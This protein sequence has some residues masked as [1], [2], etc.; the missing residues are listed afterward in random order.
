[1]K[2]SRP[3]L[4]ATVVAL[5]TSLA[6]SG[7]SQVVDLFTGDDPVFDSALPADER[8]VPGPAYV[9]DA[10]RARLATPS[11]SVTLGALSAG[12]WT[13]D[14]HFLAVGADDLRLVAPTGRVVRTV[15][16]DPAD[17]ELGDLRWDSFSLTPNAASFLS[18]A[19]PLRIELYAPDL[20]GHRVIDV[21]A[22][23]IATDQLD[24]GSV[25]DAELH[26]HGD[27]ITLDGVTWVEW[28]INSEDDTKTDHGVLRIT[29]E[30]ED[31]EVTEV[32][33]NEPV[34]RLLPAHDGSALLVLRQRNGS[35]EDCGG[36]VVEQDLVELDPA[37]G[38]VA[39]EYGMPPGYDRHWRVDA[40]DKVGDT[41]AV[42]FERRIREVEE[43]LA[44]DDVED[45]DV[46]ELQ[47]WTYDGEWT[48]VQAQDGTA[49]RWLEG[50]ALVRTV[51]P[52]AGRSEAG[53]YRLHWLP[54]GVET[55]DD[56]GAELL[57]DGRSDRRCERFE[58]RSWCPAAITPGTLLPRG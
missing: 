39:A 22:D 12:A 54:D 40:V 32:L 58:E 35:N 44:D 4:A 26:L 56:A 52:G 50:G 42:R 8:E 48:H 27:P 15:E 14:G 18:Y 17:P 38:E 37:T 41:V 49:V 29:G 47:L 30:G 55:V 51:L 7:C 23:A 5:A 25:S 3:L 13:R 20:T 33:R 45:Q 28:S 24:P 31:L 1:M 57:F 2:R 11:G 21:P 9:L 34:V 16:R 10:D 6:A 43:D 46:H 19:A 53:A 36:C